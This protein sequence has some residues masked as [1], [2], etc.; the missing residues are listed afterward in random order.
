MVCTSRPRRLVFTSWPKVWFVL[1]GLEVWFVL[2]DLEVWFVL[3]HL[4]VWF[5]L[6]GLEVWFVLLNLEVWFVLL[7]LEVWFVLLDL[8]HELMNVYNVCCSRRL[9]QRSYTHQPSKPTIKN[10]L[11]FFKNN[12][13]LLLIKR[14]AVSWRGNRLTSK[15]G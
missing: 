15:W 6:L 4:E 5:V 14:F 12:I 10:A 11:F 1:L 3:L 2:L 13:H 8:N 9:R 7:D